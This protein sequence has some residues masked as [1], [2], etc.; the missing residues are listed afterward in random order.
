ME[1]LFFESCKKNDG[2]VAHQKF[3]RRAM[4]LKEVADKGT[5]FSFSY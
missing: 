4:V 1:A 5:N 2:E 3:A